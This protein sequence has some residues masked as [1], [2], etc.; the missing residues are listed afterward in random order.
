MRDGD[1]DRATLHALRKIV[2][3][4]PANQQLQKARNIF[5]SVVAQPGVNA[6]SI[7]YSARL[8]RNCEEFLDPF[9]FS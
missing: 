9:V 6:S 7:L 1:I 3:A 8:T 5:L 4:S 2:H